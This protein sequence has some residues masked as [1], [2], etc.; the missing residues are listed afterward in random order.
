MI[1]LIYQKSY[2]LVVV[3][4]CRAYIIRKASKIIFKKV[5]VHRRQG[6]WTSALIQP[7]PSSNMYFPE[8][9]LYQTLQGTSTDDMLSEVRGS[10]EKVPGGDHAGVSDSQ[11]R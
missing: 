9:L 2:S 5:K 8:F 11:E 6:D 3:G 7:S 4:K 1:T 10:A